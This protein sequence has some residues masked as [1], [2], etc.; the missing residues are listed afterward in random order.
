M[1]ND[2]PPFNEILH[3]HLRPWKTTGSEQKFR[4][5]LHSLPKENYHHQPLYEVAFTKPL[6]R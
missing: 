5:L 2:L 1:P 4:E 3:L 6:I